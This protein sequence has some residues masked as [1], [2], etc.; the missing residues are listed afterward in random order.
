[1][2]IKIPS[3][4]ILSKDFYSSFYAFFVTGVSKILISKTKHYIQI[5][6]KILFNVILTWNFF[7]FFFIILTIHNFCLIRFFG[8]CL[9][10]WGKLM[11]THAKFT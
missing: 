3:S 1:M 4:L 5:V 10:L 2:W 9:S 8:G 11:D 7:Q 6:V